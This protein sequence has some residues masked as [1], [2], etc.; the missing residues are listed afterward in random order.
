MHTPSTPLQPATR[1]QW[2]FACQKRGDTAYLHLLALSLGDTGSTAIAKLRAEY[3]RVTVHAPYKILYKLGIFWDHVV[4]VGRLSEYSATDIEAQRGPRCVL[5]SDR[6]RDSELT[7]AFRNA[8]VLSSAEGFVQRNERFAVH[9]PSPALQEGRQVILIR[10][11]LRWFGIWVSILLGAILCI[12]AG[13]I[14]GILTNSVDLGIGVMSGLAT[15]IASGQTFAFWV[16][17]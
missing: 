13:V 7:A 14:V 2:R 11:E 6:R 3:D 15:I 10:R 1:T 4:E 8:D 12:G 9:S 5:V 16:Y 17:K